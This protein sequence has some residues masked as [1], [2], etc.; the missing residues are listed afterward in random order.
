MVDQSQEGEHSRTEEHNTSKK[1]KIMYIPEEDEDT[2]T[3]EEIRFASKSKNFYK[4]TDILINEEK[5]KYLLELAKQGAKLPIDYDLETLVFKEEETE[6]TK[7]QNI[8]QALQEQLSQLIKDKA[9][10]KIQFNL[11][12]NFPFPF[13]KGLHMPPFPK[14]V[15]I[16]KYDKYLGTS[17]PLDHLCEFGD[18]SIEFIHDQ[19]YLLRL[20]P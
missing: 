12:E 3:P 19:T 14:G 2:I 11:N 18:L 5:E 4:M 17:Y 13:D 16:P 1:G 15:E 8:V 6:T 10:P 9:K 20:F 7:L